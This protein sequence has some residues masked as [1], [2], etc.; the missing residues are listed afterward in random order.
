MDYAQH[1]E[2]ILHSVSTNDANVEDFQESLH[3]MLQHH[4][5][6]EINT[7]KTGG[8]GIYTQDFLLHTCLKHR[9]STPSTISI[10]LCL[11]RAGIDVNAE[12]IWG[13]TP[14]K[15]AI[16]NVEDISVINAMLQH[17]ANVH[18]LVEDLSYLDMALELYRYEVCELL[19]N[20]GFNINA[21]NT[22]CISYGQYMPSSI[23]HMEEALV[24]ANALFYAIYHCDPEQIQFLLDHGANPNATALHLKNPVPE[25]NYSSGFYTWSIRVRMCTVTPLYLSVI[26]QKREATE[27]LLRAGADP[28]F[29]SNSGESLFGLLDLKIKQNFRPAVDVSAFSLL[30]DYGLQMSVKRKNYESARENYENRGGDY[31]F[32]AHADASETHNISRLIRKKIKEQKCQ[33]LAMALHDRLGA[34]APLSVLGQDM[35]RHICLMDA[36]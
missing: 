1:K 12:N 32:E 10:A 3:Y 28:N 6:K 34:N 9:T 11:I 20:A 15:L 24:N 29:T 13:C 16:K 5:I 18:N 8:E 33:A 27:R 14:M 26:L 25:H 36:N 17:G 7:W 4:T 22:N 23:R 30:F 19:L 21:P 31:V 2:N 35:I